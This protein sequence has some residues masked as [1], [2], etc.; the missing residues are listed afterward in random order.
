MARLGRVWREGRAFTS[1]DMRCALC[2]WTDRDL[3]QADSDRRGREQIVTVIC[4]RAKCRVL[5]LHMTK[6]VMVY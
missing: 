6:S 2:D 4:V 3:R 5:I 1:A